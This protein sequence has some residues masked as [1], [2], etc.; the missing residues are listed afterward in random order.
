MQDL[1]SVKVAADH[2]IELSLLTRYYLPKSKQRFLMAACSV[3]DDEGAS[4][5]V[6]TDKDGTLYLYERKSKVNKVPLWPKFNIAGI[7]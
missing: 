2:N 6:C 7:V 1:Y 4:F 3:C 5:M